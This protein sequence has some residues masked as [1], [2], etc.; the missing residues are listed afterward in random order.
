[1]PVISFSGDG[2]SRGLNSL[3]ARALR[4]VKVQ[5]VDYYVERMRIH[6]SQLMEDDSQ[7]RVNINAR[8]RTP[9][10]QCWRH[11][12]CHEYHK[13]KEDREEKGTMLPASPKQRLEPAPVTLPGVQVRTS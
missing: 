2:P 1:M 5:V 8:L 11:G 12:R 7:Y 4:L 3:A 6:S 9:M 10:I 13:P